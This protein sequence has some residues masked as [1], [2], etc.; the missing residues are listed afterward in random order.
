MALCVIFI[1]NDS[2]AQIY[3]SQVGWK[4]ICIYKYIMS[5]M[6]IQIDVPLKKN[7]N[8]TKPRSPAIQ[9][10]RNPKR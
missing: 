2:L 6:V 9:T 3:L 5:Q 7:T 8:K 1:V 4:N 10:E